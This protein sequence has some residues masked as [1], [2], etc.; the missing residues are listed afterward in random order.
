MNFGKLTAYL[1][2][3]SNIGIPGSDCIV[4]CGYDT[5]YRHFSGYADREAQLPMTGEE[6]VFLHSCTKPVVCLAAMQLYERGMFLLSDPLSE[7]LPEFKDLMIQRTLSDGTTV[8]EKAKNPI[9]VLD[10]FTMSAGYV[11]YLRSEEIRRVCE[12]TGGQA[13]TR[14]VIRA[15]AKHP[16][17]YEPGTR[18]VY[19]T[20]CHDILGALI[21]ELTGMTFGEYLR[22]NIFL[23]LGMTKTGF[24]VPDDLSP[25][26]NRDDA[27]GKVERIGPVNQYIIGPA[28]ESGGAGLISCLEDYAK[29]AAALANGGKGADGKRILASA[30]LELMRT[31]HLT[32]Q[33]LASYDWEEARGYGYGLGVRTMMDPVAGGS[34]SPVGEFGWFGAAG[35]YL[36]VDPQRKLSLFYIQH[37]LENR[38]GPAKPRLRNSRIRN[39][40]YACLD[41]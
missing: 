10:L 24:A 38:S 35:H 28:Y 20:I 17:E 25:Q 18:W 34:N 3:L 11:K 36:L 9:R 19:S 14:E 31:N 32:P 5:V 16:L 33:Q 8:L 40:L 41:D 22:K 4:Q 15:F 12:E 37:V 2:S 13:P 27:A 6:K 30:T 21:E 1:D 39:I 23:P 26:Y 29:F 7:Y